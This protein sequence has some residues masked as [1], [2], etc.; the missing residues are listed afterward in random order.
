MNIKKILSAITAAALA[1]CMT[2]CGAD[3]TRE[4]GTIT[5]ADLSMLETVTETAEAEDFDGEDTENG[6]PSNDDTK[7]IEDREG[8]VI[9]VRNNV[10]TIVSAAP[11]ISEILSGLGLANKI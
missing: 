2:A 3:S 4:G 6:S 11:S 8:N 1:L 9:E 5:T 7:M 10:Q